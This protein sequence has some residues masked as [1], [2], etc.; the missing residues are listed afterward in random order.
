MKK[1]RPYLD[2]GFLELDS[3][4][5]EWSMKPVALGRKNYLFVGS[6]GGGKSAEIGTP[7][8]DNMGPSSKKNCSQKQN[9][10]PRP[11]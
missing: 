1:L 5:A 2:H 8:F 9:D 11:P 10:Y 7:N 3:N 4:S 6:E